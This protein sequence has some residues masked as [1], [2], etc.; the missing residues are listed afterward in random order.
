MGLEGRAIVSGEVGGKSDAT[1]AGQVD[2]L[3]QED[4]PFDLDSAYL[5]DA[6]AGFRASFLRFLHHKHV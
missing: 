4:R 5:R 1:R 2:R 3:A 6:S